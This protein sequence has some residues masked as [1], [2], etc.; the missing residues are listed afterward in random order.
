MSF[1]VINRLAIAITRKRHTLKAL[2]LLLLFA[3]A[4]AAVVHAGK[5]PQTYTISG[6]VADGFGIHIS[7]ATVTL[8]GSQSGTTTSDGDGNYSF[9]NLQAG[10]NYNLGVSKPGP[11]YLGSVVSVNNLS[12]DVT[13]NLRLEFLRHLQHSH[14]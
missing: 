6:V 8:S 2:W 9:A 14:H 11:A 7:G 13:K 10:S 3:V 4:P 5:L 12:S 1:S